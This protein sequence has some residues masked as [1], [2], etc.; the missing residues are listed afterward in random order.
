MLLGR[1]AVV[2]LDFTMKSEL[3]PLTKY[4]AIAWLFLAQIS[5]NEA[6][7]SLSFTD[8]SLLMNCLAL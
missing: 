2:S 5:L 8:E 4:V 3:W 7:I 6:G 1:L